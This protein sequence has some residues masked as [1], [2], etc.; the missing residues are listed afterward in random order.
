MRPKLLLVDD[1][2]HMGW[3]LGQIL[4]DEYDLSFAASGQE[5]V[6]LLRSERPDLALVD[7]RLGQEDGLE[8]LRELHRVQPGMPVIV[9]TAYA[10]VKTAV[11]AMKAG[12]FDYVPKPF[13]PDELKL[14]LNRALS[15]ARLSR[16]VEELEAELRQRYGQGNLVAVSPQMLRVLAMAEK[17]AASNAPVL[18][19]GESGT[20]KEVVARTI[21]ALSPRH[22]GPFVAVNCA[23]L[24]ESLLESE[25]FGYEAGAFTGARSRKPGRFE[26]AH[27]GTL[28]LDELADMPLPLQAKIL[29]VLEDGEVFPLGARRACPV[30]VRVISCT[31]RD[32]L[33]QVQQGMFRE[34]LYF[35]LAVIPIHLPPLRERREDIPF[36]AQHFARSFGEKYGKHVQ[37]SPEALRCLQGYGWPGNVRELRN[38]MEQ[39]VILTEKKVLDACDLPPHITCPPQST[40][41]A[42]PSQVSPDPPPSP[43]ARTVSTNPPPQP[44]N[45]PPNPLPS[46]PGTLPGGSSL[47]LAASLP[48]PPLP[49][50]QARQQAEWVAIREALEATGGNRTQAARRLGISRRALLEKLRRMPGVES[51]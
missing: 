28:L 13:D 18:I 32:L 14:T 4:G 20:G 40:P 6:A 1:E 16:R 26:N 51:P 39:M 12:A 9:L 38:L 21:H 47:R 31:N 42:P 17:I 46:P 11:Q 22:A 8:L 44:P 49:L 43:P 3:L 10:T 34:D 37:L 19:M 7:L 24:P 29:R 23:A 36:L 25:L 5:A 35:R 2:P 45:T 33:R 48:R 50:R 15:H 41:A 27:G 30:D